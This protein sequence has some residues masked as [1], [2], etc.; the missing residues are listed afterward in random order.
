VGIREKGAEENIWAYGRDIT[1]RCSQY[2]YKVLGNI[3]CSPNSTKANVKSEIEVQVA[4]VGESY[5]LHL[6][7]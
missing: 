4:C 2:Q 5:L 7:D 1:E 6:R 3:D